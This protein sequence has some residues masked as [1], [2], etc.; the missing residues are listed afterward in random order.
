MT[1][2][3][4]STRMF[5]EENTYRP[6]TFGDNPRAVS[7][8]FKL[9]SN[10]SKYCNFFLFFIIFFNMCAGGFLLYNT[11]VSTSILKIQNSH[12]SFNES[13]NN[14]INFEH[15]VMQNIFKTLVLL[16]ETQYAMTE[17]I[18]RFHDNIFIAIATIAENNPKI[19][20]N[21]T[22]EIKNV[23]KLLQHLFTNIENSNDKI[24]SSLEN[25]LNSF[26]SEYQEKQ[27][28]ISNK[29]NFLISSQNITNTNS[30]VSKD[31]DYI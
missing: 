31:V 29:L 16:N 28:K 30:S 9:N 10:K 6:T 7:T 20:S 4:E 15:D 11:F 3:A 26:K 12:N 22:Q 21:F 2:E 18:K 25:K 14:T 13:D 24:T 27:E 5:V 19:I 8:I 23:E 17:K 1:I